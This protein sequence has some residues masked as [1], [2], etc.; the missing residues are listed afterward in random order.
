M[1]HP[2]D[3]LYKPDNPLDLRITGASSHDSICEYLPLKSTC[4]FDV[5]GEK[6]GA[7]V[8][9]RGALAPRTF[10]WG[11]KIRG[12]HV[13]DLATQLLGLYDALSGAEKS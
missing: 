11:F 5:F 1:F 13:Y 10:V 2:D 4:E 12:T 9:A 8:L 3:T 6:A 7:L